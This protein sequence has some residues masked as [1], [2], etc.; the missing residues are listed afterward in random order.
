MG[1]VTRAQ[2]TRLRFEALYYPDL[3]HVVNPR[4][5]IGLVTMW[6]PWR[7]VERKLGEI[8]PEV[9]D[10]ER[11]RV[12]V[13]ANL[14]G[15]GM[16]AMF[17]NLLYNPQVRHLVAIGERLGLST[18]DEIEA[19]L[20][21][22]L[23]DAVVLGKPV[24]RVRGTER[25]FPVVAGF[26]AARL[27]GVSFRYLGK[28]SRPELGD[29]L[30]AC[31]ADLPQD[32]ADAGERVRVEIPMAVPDDYSFRPSEVT[33]HQVVRA[34]PLDCWQ[35]LVVRAVRFGRPVTLANG[36]RIELLN[37]KVVITDPAHDP[38]AALAEFGFDLDRFDR[39]GRRMLEP[40]LPEGISYT[41]GNRLRSYFG[42][43]A[44]AAAADVLRANPESR[45]AYVSLWDTNG[46]LTGESGESP[47]LVTL[48]FRRSAEGE[49]TLSAT[50]RAHNLAVAWLENVYGLMA[51]QRWMADRTGMP[52]G[53]ITVLSHSLGIDP[54][55]PRYELARTIAEAWKRDDDVDRE[56][57]KSSLREDPNGYFVVTV[58]EARGLI[59][60]EHRFGGVLIK[61]YE[62]PRAVAIEQ[63]VAADMAISLISHAMWLGRELTAKEQQLRARARA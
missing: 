27:R 23:E 20:R 10:P 33:G 57:G 14:Y 21:D 32:D 44:L 3:L 52:A 34:R 11:S 62:S 2:R 29:E 24:K 63:E 18:T 59:I 36:P 15:D 16:H 42:V 35:E 40:E 19:F 56:T 39:Y 4:G 54:R 25:I 9:L 48:F 60:A 28:L 1:D 7:T 49:L 6:S 31:V 41:Y 38:R 47:C 46:D 53:A 43:D 50:Y 13:V 5:D 26:D 51:I 55:S 12:A 8:A 61:R 45:H 37:T 22:G 30:R 17:C 58:D